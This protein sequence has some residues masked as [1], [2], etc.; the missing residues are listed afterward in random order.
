MPKPFEP[1]RLLTLSAALP[2]LIFLSCGREETLVFPEAPVVFISIDTLRSDRLPAYGYSGVETPAID[3]LRTD[4]ILFQNAYSHYPLTL[5][6]HASVLTGLLP[7][8]H[9]VRDNVG[10]HLDTSGLPF[11]PRFLK[12]R[13]YKTGGAVSAYILRADTG[14]GDDFDFYED[15]FNLRSG[16]SLGQNQRPGTETASRAVEWLEQ[17]KDEKFFLFFHIYD[18]HT[19][20]SPP[21][22]FRS[23]Y[24]NPY[25]GEVAA[26]D[27]AVG[28]LVAALKRLGV[29]EQSIIVLFADH[30]EGLSDHGELEHGIFLYREA[31]QIP[32]LLK[33]PDSARAGESVAA[34]AQLAD[35]TPT[36][37][38]LLGEE[39]EA[40]TLLDLMGEAPPER[41]I[42]AETYYPRLHLGWSELTSLID[43][44]LHYI[45]GPD[46]ELYDLVADP[47]QKD[48][49]LAQRRNEYRD[50]RDRLATFEKELEAPGE[51][52][53]E[54]RER[55]A[56][57]GYLGTT[58]VTGDGPLPDPKTKIQVLTVLMEA[59]RYQS[60]RQYAK[61]IERFREVLEDNP[62]LV[63]GWENLAQCLQ[64]MGRYEESAAA[65]EQ[66]L[67]LSQGADH[68]AL[69]A[70]RLYLETE[71]YEE[72]VRHAELALATNPAAAHLTLARIE[73]ARDD[74][75][76]AVAAARR[77]LE[78][79]TNA[80]GPYLVMTQAAIDR[81]EIEQAA[82]HLAQAERQEAKRQA[83]E[84][85]PGL[86]Y[87]KGHI[88]A[89]R[90]DAAKAE[91]SFL[92]ELHHHPS[93]TRAY[94]ELALLYALSQRPAEASAILRR[95]VENNETPDAYAAAV[96]T[97]RVLGDLRSAGGLLRVALGRFPDNVKL[98]GLFAEM[99]QGGSNLRNE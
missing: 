56:A 25:D 16:V 58:A 32:L 24:R 26:S 19:P 96:E 44:G 21:E 66:A 22:P 30:G 57:L 43:D 35:L 10:Y 50:L 53:A 84:V 89:R 36:V 68:V 52:D 62:G 41:P 64:Y 63:D 82:E 60:E 37:R 49:V 2:A 70:A 61:A 86:H 40:T 85:S 79:R 17:V 94:S 42:Y 87:L 67:T 8:E 20:Y 5:P 90:G 83:V 95:M 92:K 31:L 34:P 18:P 69:G 76:A 3:A 93:D 46:P 47:A 97:L 12:K 9:G 54:T 14:I 27:A 39:E 72:A 4:S 88:E 55:L 73:L 80:V 98:R 23:R 75:E 65:Y 1:L 59:S 78:A 74:P 6:A 48:N 45:E 11:L 33:L 77:S 29:Y 81:G 15:S 28:E 13:G 99:S 38:A 91:A 7:T 51:V 71:R